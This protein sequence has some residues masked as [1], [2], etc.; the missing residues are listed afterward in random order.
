MRYRDFRL[1][2]GGLF[3]AL[4]VAQGWL[5]LEMTDSAAM[6]ALA[7]AMLSLPFL[8]LGPF[9]GV[10]ADRV[11][12]K[13]LLVGTRSTVSA[14]MFIE[15][16]LIL[17]GR[18]EI[19]HLLVLA[20]LAGCAFAMDIPAR[21]SLIPDTVPSRVVANAVAVNVALFSRSRDRLRARPHWRRLVRAAASSRTGSA[22]RRSPPR[23]RGCG[24]RG[25]LA[26]APSA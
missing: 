8:V 13:H 19:W 12:R 6:V 9:S 15:G 3:M 17:S 14:L 4:S 20:F 24:F 25:A 2:L 26:R 5:V 16:V 23:S 10:I 21:Q 7:G 18:A 1:L 11:Y 22:T